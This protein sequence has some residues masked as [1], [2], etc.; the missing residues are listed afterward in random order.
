MVVQLGQKK[1]QNINV[2]TGKGAIPIIPNRSLGSLRL[3]N[4]ASGIYLA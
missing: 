1:D 3:E 4:S 2:I